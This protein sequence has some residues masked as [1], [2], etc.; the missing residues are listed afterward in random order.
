[1]KRKKG[2]IIAFL[3]LSVCTAGIVFSRWHMERQKG[4]LGDKI[5]YF[6]Q[7]AA[8]SNISTDVEKKR[9][10]SPGSGKSGASGENDDGGQDNEDNKMGEAAGRW[11]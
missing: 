2:Y 7:Q 3:F 8:A 10:S 6:G 9:G 1:M 11:T 4:I 5:I